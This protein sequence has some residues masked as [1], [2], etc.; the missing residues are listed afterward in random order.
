[1]GAC[2][3]SSKAGCAHPS[4]SKQRTVKAQVTPN[5]QGT[6]QGGVI[7]PLLANI[8][9]NPLDHQINE[10]TCQ[11]HRLIRYAD[12]FVVLSPPG[13]ST[14]AH[15]QIEQ[16]LASRGLELNAHKTRTVNLTQEGIRFL[17]FR[18]KVRPPHFN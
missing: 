3:R 5:R 10:S 4:W 16:W 17:G 15:Q 13:R 18:V 7:P 14:E 11:R 1:M 2:W 8:Y 9:L 12:D 6:P